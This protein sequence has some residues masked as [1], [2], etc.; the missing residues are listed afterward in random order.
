MVSL[1]R[2]CFLA[3][4]LSASGCGGDSR[5]AKIAAPVGSTSYRV[6]EVTSPADREVSFSLQRPRNDDAWAGDIEQQ[7]L[8]AGW[9]ACGGDATWGKVRVRGP[10]AA[11]VEAERK[12]RFYAKNSSTF[13]AMFAI[14]QTCASQA[15]RCDQSVVIRQ[16][17]LLPEIPDRTALV[18]AICNGAPPPANF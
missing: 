16:T 14:T 12:V 6:I 11:P 1:W 10:D 5:I 3:L 8:T 4:A 9:R 7:L 2:N 18:G 17:R 15:P 13:L